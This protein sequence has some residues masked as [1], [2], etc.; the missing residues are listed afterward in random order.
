MDALL[1]KWNL[2]EEEQK[3]VKAKVTKA[4]F[5]LASSYESLQRKQIPANIIQSIVTGRKTLSLEE[6]Q[7]IW[8]NSGWRK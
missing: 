1:R 4:Q 7:I 5:I 3:V 8:K 2:T 6:C